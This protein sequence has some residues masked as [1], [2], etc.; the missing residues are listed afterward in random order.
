MDAGIVSKMVFVLLIG[1][2][3]QILIKTSTLWL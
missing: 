1:E 3:A 2:E